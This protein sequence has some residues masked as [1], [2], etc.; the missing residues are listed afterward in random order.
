MIA[1]LE[2]LIKC[3]PQ[4]HSQRDGKKDLPDYSIFNCIDAAYTNLT[5]AL[6]EILN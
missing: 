3:I 1:Y 5:S 6:Q 2:D 4:N